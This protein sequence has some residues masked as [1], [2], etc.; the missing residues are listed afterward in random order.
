MKLF[1]SI[2]RS[3]LAVIISLVVAFVLLAG[4]ILNMYLLPYP[5]WF[6]AANVVVFLLCIYWGVRVGRSTGNVK[7]ETE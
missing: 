5:V 6:E 7:V 1:G 4:V 3:A 2:I